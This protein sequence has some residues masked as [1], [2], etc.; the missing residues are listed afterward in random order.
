SGGPGVFE[1]ARAPGTKRLLT[2]ERV[3]ELTVRAVLANRPVVRTPW[4]VRV[5]PALKG[6]V[7]FRVY[8]R[9]AALLGVNTSMVA[10][11]GR[12]TRGPEAHAPLRPWFVL[13]LG[14]PAGQIEH[15]PHEA[16]RLH[17]LGQSWVPAPQLRGQPL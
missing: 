15:R 8:Y 10:W 14:R 6:I 2:P 1:G 4:L 9:V 17:R 11:R 3:A 13:G 7:P 5:T 12:E 16:L